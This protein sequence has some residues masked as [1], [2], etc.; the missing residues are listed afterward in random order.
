MLTNIKSE[1]NA[2]FLKSPPLTLTGAE[3]R[4]R[5]CLPVLQKTQQFSDEL[6][7]YTLN[8]I[9][10]LLTY[11]DNIHTFSELYTKH[12]TCVNCRKQVSEQFNSRN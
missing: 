4:F 3:G 10:T 11:T 8:F 6:Q 7:N 2:P 9:H 5:P 12:G 1:C